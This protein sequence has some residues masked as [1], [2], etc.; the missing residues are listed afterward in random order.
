MGLIVG[1]KEIRARFPSAYFAKYAEVLRA[2]VPSIENAGTIQHSPCAN[3]AGIGEGYGPGFI[4]KHRSGPPDG[5]VGLNRSL[6][7]VTE[8][9]FAPDGP[10]NVASQL[11]FQQFD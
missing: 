2:V 3:I 8:S 4:A 5:I 10:D 7:D 9:G 11:A 6:D 1:T